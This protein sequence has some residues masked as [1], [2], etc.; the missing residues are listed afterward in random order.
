M[1]MRVSGNHAR[2]WTRKNYTGLPLMKKEVFIAWAK[3]SSTLKRLFKKW[4]HSSF[5]HRHTPTI[6]RLDNDKRVGYVPGNIRWLP[7]YI[8]SSN[9][10]K[11]G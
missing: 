5:D 11:N 7:Q 4:V 2:E 1:K 8:N 10:A 6:D 9:G 3:R